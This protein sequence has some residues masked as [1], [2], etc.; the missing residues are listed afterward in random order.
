MIF[1]RVFVNHHHFELKFSLLLLYNRAAIFLMNVKFFNQT[2][3]WYTQ[4][5]PFFWDWVL[6]KYNF[7]PMLFLIAIIFCLLDF[8]VEREGKITSFVSL[9]A[10]DEL[11]FWREERW[12]LILTTTIPWP[13][14]RVIT[15]SKHLTSSFSVNQSLNIRNKVLRV[16]I[17]YFAKLSPLI[18]EHSH[19]GF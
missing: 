3:S 2:S 14:V 4:I 5:L 11:V 18:A 8:Y 1:K 10:S 16:S 6:L 9:S 17:S 13:A 7:Q 12:Y 19:E 15:K